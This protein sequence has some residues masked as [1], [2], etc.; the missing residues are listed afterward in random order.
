MIYKTITTTSKI[1]I[2]PT[3]DAAKI[4]VSWPFKPPVDFPVVPPLHDSSS[5]PSLQSFVPSHLRVLLRHWCNVRHVNSVSPQGIWVGKTRDELV[6]QSGLN[7]TSSIAISLKNDWPTIPWKEKRNSKYSNKY[8]KTIFN[9]LILIVHSQVKRQINTPIRG[10][11]FSLKLS[12][13]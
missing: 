11:D 6:K 2:P 4:L 10:I 1:T 9:N 3:I 5:E 12:L 7:V 13:F 8:D